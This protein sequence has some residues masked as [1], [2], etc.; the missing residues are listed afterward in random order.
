MPAN[1]LA[2]E[3]GIT[4]EGRE[5]IFRPSFRKIAELE[6]PKGLVKL[7]SDVHYPGLK[8]LAASLSVLHHFIDAEPEEA[9]RLL[10]YYR[11]VKG[12]LRY[13]RGLIVEPSDLS[14][15]ATKILLNAMVGKPTRRKGNPAT[16]FD[17]M[18]FVGAA[19]AHLSLQPSEAWELTMHE[20]QAAITAKFG[21][22]KEDEL[23][24]AAEID[25]MW[26][27]VDKCQKT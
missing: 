17:T 20:F 2:G 24:T 22:P 13:V 3:I 4:A 16:E 21:A 27:E 5:Y 10:G 23:P 6:S 19:I 25:A 1:L 15:L 18:G 7:F 14:V 26:D 12:R 8:G 11:D 9:Q